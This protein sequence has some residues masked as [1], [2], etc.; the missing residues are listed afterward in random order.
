[1]DLEGMDGF[2][3]QS[4]GLCDLSGSILKQQLFRHLDACS[5]CC[6]AAAGNRLLRRHC[7]DG[8]VWEPLVSKQGWLKQN[9]ES[10]KAAY[11]RNHA[12]LCTMCNAYTK[13][14]FSMTGKRLCEDCE[15]AHPDKYSLVTV[16]EATQAY[17]LSMVDLMELTGPL[18][19]AGTNF[20]LRSEVQ[21]VAAT[22][23]TG[24]A[25][26]S[27][28]EEGENSEACHSTSWEEKGRKGSAKQSKEEKKAA[29]KANK[30]QVKQQQR[31]KR[32]AG[33]SPSSR[34]FGTSPSAFGSSPPGS[35]HRKKAPS[36]NSRRQSHVR[37]TH[38]PREGPSMRAVSTCSEW[39]QEREQLMTEYGEFGISGLALAAN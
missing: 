24:N 4:I 1:M 8:T 15:H 10:W 37:H 26:S 13:Y 20:Y 7:D 3:E 11:L 6:L 17:G 5:L 2:E 9:Q 34:S 33:S 14:V 22:Q 27:G 32:I 16:C 19:K 18:K 36:S 23:R 25:E 35:W 29:R 39:I 21:S 12:Q 38:E 28:D 30:K 31:E